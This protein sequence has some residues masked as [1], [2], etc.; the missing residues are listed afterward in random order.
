MKRTAII[1]AF[2]FSAIFTSA[3]VP[4]GF[5]YQ[6]IARGSDGK[7]IINTTIGV[8]ISILSDTLGF[9]STGA[10][11][12][13]WEELHSVKTNNLGLFTLTVGDPMATKVQG[14]AGSFSA[15][16]WKV[17]PIYIGS[18]INFSGWKNM[19]TSR[20]WSV[21]YSMVAGELEGAVRKLEVIGEDVLS[22][23]ALFEVRRKDG[24]TMFA[25]YNHGVR[26]F[27]PLDTLSKARK[28]G[29]AIGGFD[30]AKGVVQDYFVVNPDSIRVYIDTNPVKARK[31]GFAIG[32]FD[33]AKI[34]N[35]EY[36]RVTRD[37]TRIYLNDTETK[38]KKGG[39][40]IGGFDKA[41]GS[42]ASFLNVA[43]DATGI[44]NPSQNRLLWYPIKNSFLVGRV[45]IG[46]PDSVGVNSF[47]SGYESKARGSYSQAMGFKSVANGD[48]STAMGKNALANGVNSFAL[49]SNAKALYEETYAFGSN[50]QASGKGSVAI[51][52]NSI[53]SGWDAFALGAGTQATGLGSFALGFEGRDSSDI[54]TGGT[55]AALRYGV[56]IGMGAQ[57]VNS[58]SPGNKG[59]FSIG[60]QTLSEGNYS[61]ALGY[62]TRSSGW[63]SF[64]AGYGTIASGN[65]STAMGYNS[66]ASG[67]HS[68]AIGQSSNASNW[69]SVAIGPRTNSGGQ[70]SMA[71]GGETTATGDYS[72]AMGR[73]SRATGAGSVSI[74]FNNEANQ[75]ATAFGYETHA[76]GNYSTSTGFRSTASGIN[77]FSAGE[78]SSASG[79]TAISLGS[80]VRATG[81]FSFATGIL[82]EARGVSSAALGYYSIASGSYSIAGGYQTL[83]AGSWSVA[84]GQYC[85]ATS[86]NTFAMGASTIAKGYLATSFGLGTKAKPFAS[87]AIGQYNDSTCS[88]NGHTSWVSTDPLLIA[89]NGSSSA[90]L[91]NAL[92]L[93][94][95]GNLTIAGTLTQNSDIRIKENIEPVTNG[96]DLIKNIEPVYFYFRDKASHPSGR[97]LGFIAQ[98]VKEAI[99]EFVSEDSQGFLSVDYTRMSAV[100]VQALK[101]QYKKIESYKIENDN[102]RSKL[103]A[104]QEKVDR[105]ETQLLKIGSR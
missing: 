1:P 23:E 92:T 93:Y 65:F 52:F 97:Q 86:W 84:L 73:L 16:D 56:A 44:I 6:A 7:E 101:E 4:Q 50:S 33:K 79:A 19:G 28:G 62:R 37:S 12:Y 90:S 30:K 77:S 26:V 49:G 14:S 67:S 41:K 47:V 34:G 57:S 75:Y 39:F 38:A 48:Y 64:A 74:G 78:Q 3:Q 88:V 36:L 95:N 31:G 104:L 69:Y 89:G 35:E 85:S 54:S 46:T 8:K 15:I 9:Y 99:P 91:S 60:I 96:Y 103:Q 13:I 21:P 76:T 22:D 18:K 10:G 5:N 81:D 100:L 59:A 29:F 55:T 94:K 11:T 98:E 63:Y 17:Q 68:V 105:I 82:T 102:L 53:A 24:E 61:F 72:L 58:I 40:A 71:I 70:Q 66:I 80:F 43:T 87:Y 45:R 25:V 42:N 20:L 51:G 32:G 2:L 27:M 83:A